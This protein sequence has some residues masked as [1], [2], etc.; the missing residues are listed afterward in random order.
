MYL[1]GACIEKEEFVVN[2][3]IL[4]FESCLKVPAPL[5]AEL[6]LLQD[7]DVVCIQDMDTHYAH[8][9]YKLL[10][11]SYAHFLY[12]NPSSLDGLLLVSSLW[13]MPNLLPLKTQ[14][15]MVKAV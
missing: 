10:L 4:N 14:K 2:L 1:S 12:M 3:H 13:K 5:L 9:L 8:G 7:A 6:I 11:E 15:K